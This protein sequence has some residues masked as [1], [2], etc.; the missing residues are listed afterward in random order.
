MDATLI[1]AAI[2]V[3]LSS[4]PSLR[5]PIKIQLPKIKERRKKIIKCCGFKKCVSST[6]FNTTRTGTTSSS[7]MSKE[8]QDS[9]TSSIVPQNAATAT[10]STPD[11]QNSQSHDVQ[12]LRTT[13]IGAMTSEGNGNN[14]N[15]PTTDYVDSTPEGTDTRT[16]SNV[17]IDQGGNSQPAVVNNQGGNS[18]QSSV[19]NDQGAGNSQPAAPTSEINLNPTAEIGA[20]SA[21]ANA[22]GTLSAT[23]MSPSSITSTVP[24]DSKTVTV[25]V[26]TTTRPPTTTSTAKTTTTTTTTTTSTTTVNPTVK[27]SPSDGSVLTATTCNKKQYYVSNVVATRN[28]AALRCKSMNMT[29][30][31]VASLEEMDCLAAVKVGTFWTSG[32]NEDPKCDLEKKYAWCSTGFNVS[33]TLTSSKNYWLPTTAAPSAL[34]RCLAVVTSAQN[35]G[36][37]HRKCDDTLNYVCQFAVDCPK[38]CTKNDSLFDSS[39]KLINETSYGFWIDIGNYTYL[40]GNK[41]MTWLDSYLHC[42]ALGME[43]LNLDNLAE[44]NGLTNMTKVFKVNWRLNYNYWTSGTWKGAPVNQWAWCEPTGPTVLAPNLK[45]EANQ[46]DNFNRSESCVHFRFVLNATGTIMTDRTC[47]SRYIFACKMPLRTTPKPCVVSC[48]TEPC[49]RNDSYFDSTTS[50]KY[51]NNYFSF[52]EWYDACGRNFLIYKSRLSN[53]KTARQQCCEIGTTLASMESTGKS[54]CFSKIAAKFAP[55]T[56]G[57]FWLSG[58][59]LGCPSNFRWCS[60]NLDFVEPEI[61]WKDGHPKP[62]LDCVYLEVR[63]GS[64]LLATANCTE[65]KNFLC[66]IRKKATSQKAMQTECAE[67]WDISIA[68]IDLLLNTAKFLTANVSLNLKCFL[69]CVGVEVGLFDLG[70]LKNIEMLRQIELVT[71]EDPVKM[72]QGFVA[73][74]ECSGK[75]YDD[76]CENAYETYKCGQQKEPALVSKIVKLNFGNATEYSPPGP[77]VPKRRTCWMSENIPCQ[78]NQT[79]YGWFNRTYT[80]DFGAANVYNGKLYYVSKPDT[81]AQASAAFAYKHCCELGLVLMEPMTTAQVETLRYASINLGHVIAGETEAINQTHEVWCRSRKVIPDSLYDPTYQRYQ[82]YETVV[83]FDTGGSMKVIIQSYSYK[84]ENIIDMYLNPQKYTLPANAFHGY[85]CARP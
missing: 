42:C 37:V 61:K 30:L 69:K 20:S 63:N 57:D 25:I 39:G 84:E 65:K 80:D 19:A 34:E 60:R 17:V 35:K 10:G 12:T 79:L 75:N 82:C 46:P 56:F 9:R 14:N 18:Q 33:N 66:E 44:Q 78:I 36:M 53:W 54:E 67:I 48:P 1:V 52:G 27:P 8:S 76:E 32:S 50:Y 62:D 74:D 83:G 59:D 43:A 47:E 5:G 29:L 85:M 72:Q 68:Q 70:A 3:G 38:I 64:Q 31:T 51:L 23:P 21:A 7:M 24:P 77:C 26:K 22:I 81:G 40:L 28:E 6:R 13:D 55:N 49:E 11:G 73:F 16:T 71:M 58:T 45:W 2:V 41:P 4:L 15:N